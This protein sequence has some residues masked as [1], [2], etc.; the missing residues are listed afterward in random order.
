MPAS[1]VHPLRYGITPTSL[2]AIAVLRLPFTFSFANRAYRQ[3]YIQF[4]EIMGVPQHMIDAHEVMFRNMLGSIRGHIYYNL[5]NW[6]RLVH[7]LPGMGHNASFMETMMGVRQGLTPE[8]ASLFDF[9]KRTTQVFVMAPYHCTCNISLALYA[10]AG[11]FET[12][13]EA[14]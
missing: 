1:T 6:Y 11:H 2:K 5:V 4:C 7:M 8:V 14:V 12:V 10:Y 9:I 3:V 13:L